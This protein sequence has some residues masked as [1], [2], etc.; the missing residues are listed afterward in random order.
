MKYLLLIAVVALILFSPNVIRA[1][2]VTLV[3]PGGMKCPLDKMQ[4]DFEKAIGERQS[5][6]GFNDTIRQEAQT[7][8]RFLDDAPTGRRQTGINTQ[9][10]LAI[11]WKLQ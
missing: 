1:Q 5:R 4:P 8:G 6:A 11:W 10:N 3:A 9:N 2:E 7:R